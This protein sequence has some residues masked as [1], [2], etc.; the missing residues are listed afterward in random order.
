MQNFKPLKIGRRRI[1][2]EL[3]SPLYDYSYTKTYFS[4]LSTGRHLRRRQ[5]NRN[6]FHCHRFSHFPHQKYEEARQGR[7]DAT[8]LHSRLH[9]Q[10]RASAV[11]IS[12]LKSPSNRKKA[13]T[14]LFE[15]V[16]QNVMRQKKIQRRQRPDVDSPVSYVVLPAYWHQHVIPMRSFQGAF[17]YSS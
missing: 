9:L 16:S 17:T 12:N 13:S 15:E 7:I 14:I 3:R 4:L 5:S 11:L 6:H 10:Q 2:S 8:R 1:E